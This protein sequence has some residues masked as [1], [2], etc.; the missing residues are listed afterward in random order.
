VVLDFGDLNQQK[1]LNDFINQIK[2]YEKKI[3]A[4][5]IN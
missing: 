3:N 1:F 4:D 5:F 2:D